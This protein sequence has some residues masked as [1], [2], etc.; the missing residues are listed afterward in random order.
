[1]LSCHLCL[2]VSCYSLV[3]WIL[4]FGCSFCLITWCLYFLLMKIVYVSQHCILLLTDVVVNTNISREG[5]DYL[6]HLVDIMTGAAC[7]AGNAYPSGG[8]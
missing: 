5:N 1:M 7:G 4:G 2:L 3:F 6:Y 8:S